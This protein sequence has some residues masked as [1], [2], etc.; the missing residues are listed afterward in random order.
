MQSTNRVW[1]AA[2]LL[3]LTTASQAVWAFLDYPIRSGGALIEWILVFCWLFVPL[4]AMWRQLRP[5]AAA[6]GPSQV[7][8]AIRIAVVA[9][10]PLL[11]MLRLIARLE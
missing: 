9:Y 7:D 3:F 1:L 10:P 8:G 6:A 5:G 11:F 2:G 4:V